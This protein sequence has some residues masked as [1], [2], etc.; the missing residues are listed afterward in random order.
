MKVEKNN[1]KQIAFLSLGCSFGDREKSLETAVAE[2]GKIGFVLKV[3]SIYY[4]PPMGGVA[5]N[6]FAN[7]ALEFE[8][9]LSAHDL[10]SEC[11][12]IENRLGRRRLKRWDD[13]VIDI[14]IITYNNENICT[15]DLIIPHEE[16][17]KREFVLKPLREITDFKVVDA[18]IVI[19]I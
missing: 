10:L 18:K 16:A 12:E 14:D 6:E 7:I 1:K 3:S 9:S 11:L 8:T 13:R 2:L 17:Y 5:K 4:N 19:S 15:D